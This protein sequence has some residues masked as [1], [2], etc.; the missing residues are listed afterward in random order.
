MQLLVLQYVLDCDYDNDYY[1]SKISL[2]SA[3]MLKCCRNAV[4][5]FL[6]NCVRCTRVRVVTKLCLVWD[7]VDWNT[8]TSWGDGVCSWRLVACR[9]QPWHYNRCYTELLQHHKF[10][11]CVAQD[12][13]WS[14]KTLPQ[15]VVYFAGVVFALYAKSKVHY[16]S[17]SET[18][19]LAS[20]RFACVRGC[21][22]FSKVHHASK[23][24][25]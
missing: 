12:S 18:C 20:L 17:W 15:M 11:S 19:S 14:T 6:F 9:H 16:A 21:V 8:S 25:Y 2:Q 22:V 24:K 1:Y 13:S 3:E 5:S 10:P 23:S 4:G 7:V